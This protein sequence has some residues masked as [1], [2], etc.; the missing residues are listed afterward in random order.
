[1]G[2][3]GG[4]SRGGRTEQKELE[5]GSVSS[6]EGSTME[7]AMNMIDRKSDKGRRENNFFRK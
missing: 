2:V 6:F 4:R 1:M 5:R 3:L 7:E